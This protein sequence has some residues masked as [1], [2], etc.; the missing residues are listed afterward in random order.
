MDIYTKRTLLNTVG[1]DYHVYYHYK[2]NCFLCLDEGQARR[3]KHIL[4]APYLEMCEMLAKCIRYKEEIGALPKCRSFSSLSKVL[5]GIY[6]SEEDIENAMPM[7]FEQWEKLNNLSIDWE[8]VVG[9]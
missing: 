4:E 5:R 3:Y 9:L 8:T 2:K 7:V 1:M 6:V